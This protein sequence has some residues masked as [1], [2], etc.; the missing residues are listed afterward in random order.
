MAKTIIQF[1]VDVIGW[2]SSCNYICDTGTID[3][4]DRYCCGTCGDHLIFNAEELVK[5]IKELESQL[6][7][8]QWQPITESN[9]PKEIGDYLVRIYVA[10]A[11]THYTSIETFKN[12]RFQRSMAGAKITYWMPL[13]NPPAQEP[14]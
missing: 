1:G 10:D 7:Y 14:K 3:A 6:A 2:C 9:Q 4:E 5:R 13:P 12:G 8:L 11:N